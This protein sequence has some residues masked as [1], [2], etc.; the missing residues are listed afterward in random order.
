MRRHVREY[1]KAMDLVKQ[2]IRRARTPQDWDAVLEANRRAS[3][4]FRRKESAIAALRAWLD[5]R[6][7]DIPVP[8]ATET[9]G[10]GRFIVEERQ[11]YYAARD[12]GVEGLLAAIRGNRN[13][14]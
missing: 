14:H 2:M 11:P 8:R 13:G 1:W 10:S 9:D 4:A 7:A 6:G 3:Q 5:S 12:F